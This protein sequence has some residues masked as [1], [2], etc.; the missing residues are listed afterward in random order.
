MRL[1]D[2]VENLDAVY[3]DTDEDRVVYIADDRKGPH[4]YVVSPGAIPDIDSVP[5][6]EALLTDQ[7]ATAIHHALQEWGRICIPA[8]MMHRYLFLTG[9]R[10]VI[11]AAI[12][13]YCENREF[14]ASTGGTGS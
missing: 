1:A 4:I 13:A 11:K 2:E 8:P 3:E 12:Q 7:L 6:P 14:T 9:S 10:D 5:V